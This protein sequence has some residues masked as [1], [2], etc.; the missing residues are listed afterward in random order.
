MKIYSFVYKMLSV[1]ILFI[2]LFSLAHLVS[3]G[4]SRPSHC[5]YEIDHSICATTFA[6]GIISPITVLGLSVFLGVNFFLTRFK[7][8]I[9]K[10]VFYKIYSSQNLFTISRNLQELFSSG[11]L[12][13]K[14]P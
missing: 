6:H 12:N 9:L 2:W 3:M 10:Q 13:P 5:P 14:A 8:V 7:K 1:T 4:F 11:I